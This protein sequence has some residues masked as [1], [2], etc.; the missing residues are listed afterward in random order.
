[1]SILD[2][3]LSILVLVAIMYLLIIIGIIL[4][5]VNKKR[6][7]LKQTIDPKPEE[8]FNVKDESQKR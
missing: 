4:F 5:F 7:S 6:G 2:P 1:M 8:Q 3:T